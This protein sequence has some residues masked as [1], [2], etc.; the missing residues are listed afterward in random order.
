MALNNGFIFGGNTGVSYDELQRRRQ[1]SDRLAAQIMGNKPRTALEGV[2]SML[3]GAAAGFSRYRTDKAIEDAAGKETA[4]YNQILSSI[5]GGGSAV[6]NNQTVGNLD[7]NA[8]AMPMPGA[9]SEMAATSPGSGMQSYRDAIASIESKGSGDYAAVGPSH[10]KLGRALGRYQV[11]EA[12]IGPW[13]QAALGRSVTPDEFLSNPAIQ[14]AIFDHQFKGYVDKFGPEGAAQAWFG[15]EGG[16]GKLDRKDSLGTSIAAYSDKFRNALGGTQVASASPQAA[17]DAVAPP[18]GYVD[19]MVSAP[20]AQ[21]QQQAALPQLPPPQNVATPPSPPQQPMQVA[22]DGGRQSQGINPEMLRMLSSPWLSPQQRSV[23]QMVVQQQMQEQQAAKEEQTWRAREDYRRNV[24]RSDPAYQLEQDYKRAQLNALENKT[25]NRN[26]INA[27]DG[28]LYD[29][30]QER[31]IRAPQPEAGSGDQF[32]FGGNSVDAQS[33]N[34]LI[35]TGSLS[36]QQAAEIGAG[37]TV[38]GPDGS[39]YFMT[40]QGLVGVPTGGNAPSETPEIDIF[41]GTPMANSGNPQSVP[42][43]SSMPGGTKIGGAKPPS[44]YQWNDPTDQSK[45]MTPIPGG[46][47]EEIAAEV[48]A[49]IGLA[50]TFLGKYQDLRKKLSEGRVTGMWDRV[51]AGINQSS[52]QAQLYREMESGAD[53][54]QR[55]LTGA[56]MNQQEAATYARRYLPGYT[57]DAASAVAKL[58]QLKAELEGTRAMVLRGRGNMPSPAGS[59]SSGTENNSDPLGLR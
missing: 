3:Q 50:D 53:A 29:P 28:N 22:G 23:L 7:P 47:G 44:G 1:L 54:L 20:N 51:Q 55:M 36:P 18:S 17:I 43:N 16:V 45:G 14:D 42:S 5:I 39:Q 13:S 9:A 46:P 38:T 11:M 31:W 27:G 56:G 2:A 32:R 4:A 24:E 19:P 37:K 21:P 52:S 59:A 58:D 6:P 26:L 15:G 33:L 40:P 10:P 57:D 34:Y 25:G 49:R 48:A 30:D 41:D 35:E 12:N 8:N